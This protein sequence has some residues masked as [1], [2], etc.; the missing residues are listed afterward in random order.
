MEKYLHLDVF[1]IP[2][3]PLHGTH[4]HLHCCFEGKILLSYGCTAHASL[5]AQKLPGGWCCRE[6]MADTAQ[7]WNLKD[8]KERIQ[9]SS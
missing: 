8:C 5:G 6:L 7:G 2:V 9:I 4:H 1:S 3:S